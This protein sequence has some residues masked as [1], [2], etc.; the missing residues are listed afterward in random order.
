MIR[1]SKYEG[2]VSASPGWCKPGAVG[3]IEWVCE[4]ARE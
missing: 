3:H 2:L 4:M 1:K